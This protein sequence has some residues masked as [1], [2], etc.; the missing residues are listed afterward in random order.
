[1]GELF[2]DIFNWIESLTPV[3]TYVVIFCISYGEN[4]LPPI[5]GDMIIVFGGYL[6]GI[7]DNIDFWII[8][9]LATVGGGM[10]FMT[11]YAVGYSVG[12][13]IYV[14]D[15]YR[16]IPRKKMLGVKDWVLRR[17]YWVVL[18]NR[19]LAGTRSVISLVVGISHMDVW[20][21]TAASTLSAFL[22]TG[23]ISYAGYVVGENWG[24]MSEYLR[25]YGVAILVVL[26]GIVMAVF[27]RAWIKKKRIPSRDGRKEL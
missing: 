16:W 26:L 24:I 23:I 18:A 12:E 9:A 10:G 11:L 7:N 21:T 20:R 25:L 15:K 6:A 2:A 5:P 3:W 1:M 4:V 17:G 13:S 27:L 22:W 19:F 14:S 8:W